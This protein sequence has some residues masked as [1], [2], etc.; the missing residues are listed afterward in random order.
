MAPNLKESSTE[1]YTAFLAEDFDANAYANSLLARTDGGGGG[2]S[3]TLAISSDVGPAIS[4]L[5]GVIDELHRQLRS[6]VGPDW[7]A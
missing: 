1:L 2:N 7:T 5:N 4:R 6:K 3:N